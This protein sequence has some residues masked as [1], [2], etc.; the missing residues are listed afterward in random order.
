MYF[1]KVVDYSQEPPNTKL[2]NINQIIKVIYA[3]NEPMPSLT[4]IF[5]YL[6]DGYCVRTLLLPA[7]FEREIENAIGPTMEVRTP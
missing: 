5:I 3:P 7:A 1:I 4:E 2:L 6:T